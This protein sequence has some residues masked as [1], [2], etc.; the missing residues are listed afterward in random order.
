M[1][2][3]TE[4]LKKAE[5]SRNGDQVSP[6]DVERRPLQPASEK[7]L[8]VSKSS[9]RNIT[10]GLTFILV[11]AMLSASLFFVGKLG[12]SLFDLISSGNT[13]SPVKI[14]DTRLAQ[15][16]IITKPIPVK[17]SS[18]FPSTPLP[19]MTLQGIM[20]EDSGSVA[21]INGV[22]LE[23]GDKMSGA[24]VEDILEDEVVLSYG[25]EKFYLTVR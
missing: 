24:L 18:E 23:V 5:E 25:D 10:S 16:S 11:A 22:V 7:N 2:I 4:A 9:Y 13:P 19:P 15:K 1:S 17:L 8:T 3:I 14:A 6:K 21:L 20:H 12:I